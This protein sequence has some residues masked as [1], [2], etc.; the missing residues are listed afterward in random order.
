MTAF[1]VTQQNKMV[2]AP[3]FGAH[4]GA[5]VPPDPEGLHLV[6]SICLLQPLQMCGLSNSSE[7]IS[8]SRPHSGHLQVNDCNPLNC[9]HPGQ[10]SGVVMEILLLVLVLASGSGA[11]KF[12]NF[13]PNS[14]QEGFSYP[15]RTTALFVCFV[16]FHLPLVFCSASRTK[17]LHFFLRAD[18]LFRQ[19]LG[20]QK[21]HI[22]AGTLRAFAFHYVSL[23]CHETLLRR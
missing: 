1:V 15:F 22:P 17:N 7:K 4:L 9:S 14:W 6:K 13:T 12:L 5:A 3:G 18:I 2:N 23:L 20:A 10:C 19:G 8:F 11:A 16:F 21:T